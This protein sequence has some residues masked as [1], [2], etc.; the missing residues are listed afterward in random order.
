MSDAIS[1][2]QDQIKQIDTKIE[3]AKQVLSDP[4]MAP[5]AQEEIEQLGLQ[6]KALQDSIDTI[7]NTPSGE[8]NISQQHFKEITLEVRAGAGGEEAKIF[9]E[10]LIRMYTRFCESAKLKVEPWDLGIIK[11]KGN[12]AYSLFKYESGVHRVQRVPETESSGRIHTSTASVAVLPIIP[13]TQLDIRDEDL[14][15]QFYRSGGKG[16]QNVNKVS[17]AVRLTHK[18][19]DTVVTCTSER[20]QAQNRAIALDLLRSQLWEKMEAERLGSLDEQ[21][22]AAVGSA[23]RAE[24]IKTYNFPQNRLTDHR[25]NKSWYS[26]DKILQ[27]DL[28]EVLKTTSTLINNQDDQNTN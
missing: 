10:D 28:K 18:P 6:K 3:A 22:K 7:N 20:S 27:G 13:P 15:W 21:R 24:K 17:T 1:Q 4:E 26:L 9:A 25:I 2:L 8:D 14:D 11:I 19:T 16:G 5:L 12:G 23:M